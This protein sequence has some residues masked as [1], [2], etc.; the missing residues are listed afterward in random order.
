MKLVQLNLNEMKSEEEI[1]QYLREQLELPE[2]EIN[3]LDSLRE[4]LTGWVCDN[5]CMEISR[6]EDSQSP[7]YAFSVR[8]LQMLEETAQ[9]TEEKE[10]KLYIVL[11][12]IHPLDVQSSGI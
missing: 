3:N 9:M 6:C 4:L 8:L 10:G 12:D 11:A 1:H 5:V 2:V 7:V